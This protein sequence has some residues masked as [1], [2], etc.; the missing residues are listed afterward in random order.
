MIVISG[1][2]PMA[3]KDREFRIK[4]A[5]SLL[6]YLRKYR[7]LFFSGLC[8]FITRLSDNNIISYQLYMN[9]TLFLHLESG[10]FNLERNPYFFN[11]RDY[12]IRVKYLTDVSNGIFRTY[13][14]DNN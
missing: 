7:P 2:K 1:I 3:E 11:S 13:N 12:E 5:K 4:K 6:R 14:N 8:N 9:Y 10:R